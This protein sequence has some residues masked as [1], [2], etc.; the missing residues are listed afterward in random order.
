MTP[1]QDEHKW[2]GFQFIPD[3]P[4]I[5]TAGRGIDFQGEISYCLRR[6]WIGSGGPPGLQ[7]QW[8]ALK[9]SAVGSIP[10]HFRQ[11]DFKASDPGSLPL[12]V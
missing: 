1:L 10:M 9:T 3:D 12:L 4:H 11:N 5:F 8:R 6:K 7:I 2:T